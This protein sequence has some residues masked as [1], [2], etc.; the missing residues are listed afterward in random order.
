VVGFN[1]YLWNFQCKTSFPLGRV[2]VFLLIREEIAAYCNNCIKHVNIFC[3]KKVMFFVN[4]KEMVH[5]VT[6]LLN[7]VKY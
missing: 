4:C 7:G 1:S 2:S 3:E 5:I 6:I